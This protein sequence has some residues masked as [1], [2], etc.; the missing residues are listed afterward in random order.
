MAQTELRKL[1]PLPLPVLLACMTRL[2]RVRKQS[3]F[4]LFLGLFASGF[5]LIGLLLVFDTLFGRASEVPV[6]IAGLAG[7][8]L[9]LRRWLTLR[10]VA[11]RALVHYNDVRLVGPLTEF[12]T[13]GEGDR[14]AQ[15]VARN[16]LAH[17]LPRLQPGHADLLT[18]AQRNSLHALLLDPDPTQVTAALKA[19]AQVGDEAAETAVRQRLAQ[20]PQLDAAA[21]ECLQAIAARRTQR[22]LRNNLLRVIPS[23]VPQSMAARQTE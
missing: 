1:P 17:L 9:I 13:A 20:Q 11:L 4:L 6:L 10:G 7:I 21:Q 8:A 18:P 23:D 2:E 15:I 5:L 16:L 3:P 14:E 22:R 19:L 12:V